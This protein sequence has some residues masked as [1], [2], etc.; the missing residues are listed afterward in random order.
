MFSRRVLASVA[1]LLSALTIAGATTGA[2]A[3]V[4]SPHGHPLTVRVAHTTPRSGVTP[5]MRW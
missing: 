1:A 5:D 2:T 3:A 4:A